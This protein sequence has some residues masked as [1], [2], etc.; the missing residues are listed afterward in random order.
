MMKKPQKRLKNIKMKKNKIT[1]LYIHIPFCEQ[2]C[3]Y[4]DFTK[5]QY[6]RFIAEKYLVALKKEI[7]EVVKNKDLKT[8]YVGGGTPTSL[9][10]DLFNDL[11]NIIAPFTKNVEEYTFEANPESLSLEKLKMMKEY[12]VNR[13]SIGVESTNDKI[14]KAINRN[15]TYQDVV[16]ATKN[17]LEVGFTN[18]NFDLILGLP[19]VSLKMLK[20]DIENLLSLSPTHIS[21]YSLTVHPHTVFYLNK[22]EEPT[23]DYSRDAYDMIHELLVNRGYIHY[24]ISNFAKQKYQ[25]KHNFV[26]WRNENYYGA[27]LGASGYI[28]NNRY[29]NTANLEKYLNGEYILEQEEVSQKD[30]ET[31]FI[32]LNLRTNEGIDLKLFNNIFNKDL[33][34]ARKEEIDSF[35]AHNLLILK[36]DKLIA[37]Y[38]GMMILDEI[39]LD[40]I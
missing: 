6:F 38:E 40:L 39:I 17:L 22:I 1:S 10:D 4:C 9:E 15:H 13:L 29:K 5:L 33:Y 12:G 11:L 31:Y 25:S 21:C 16:N 27:G 3:N 32:M 8:I 34:R 37:T 30:L 2:I 35:I 18:F 23:D 36:D 20:Q 7:D 19:N 14:L 26:Y 28:D 24:E